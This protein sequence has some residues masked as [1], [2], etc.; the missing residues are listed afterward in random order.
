MK[1]NFSKH[2]SFVS[3]HWHI[4]TLSNWHIVPHHRHIGTLAYWHIGLLFF[5]STLAANS[6]QTITFPSSDGLTI[7][8]DLYL[9]DKTLPYIIL[10]HQADFSRGEYKETAPRLQKLGYNCLAVDLRSGKEV[11]Y[12][13]NETAAM[14]LEKNLSTSYLDAEK[15]LI[16]AI[17]YVKKQSK[18]RIILVGSSY[19]A[20]LVLKNA[21]NNPRINAVIAFSPGEYFQPQIAFKSLLT[22][23]DK[24][25]FVAATKSEYPFV[26]EMM[27]GVQPR[28]ITWWT[29]SKAPGIH[30]SR[31]LWPSSPE[32]ESCWMSLLMFIKNLK[33][34]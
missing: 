11:N 4:G 16:A 6:Q 20:S 12:I 26:K 19:S 34:S 3:N 33:K 28:L 30:G 31:A 18:S 9:K 10:F 2:K 7:T 5:L 32:N 17:E 24:P 13:P 22:K 14:A 21:K 1:E 27:S 29:P 23:F 15:D 8:A 25:V